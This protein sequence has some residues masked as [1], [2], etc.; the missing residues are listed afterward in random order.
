MTRTQHHATVERI[1][2]EHGDV[3]LRRARRI[4]GSDDEAVDALHELFSRLVADPD[5]LDGKASIVAWLYTCTTHLCLNRLR[6]HRSRHGLALRELG[7]GGR[8]DP[9]AERLV[10]ARQTLARMPEPLAQV[11]LHAWVDEMTGEEIAE[12]LGCSRR[13]VV[14]LMTKLRAW[15]EKESAA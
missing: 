4:L 3:V 10:W 2:R 14:D 9:R 5:R 12:V 7:G 1:Y 8:Q 6:D 15:M 11:A 13:H